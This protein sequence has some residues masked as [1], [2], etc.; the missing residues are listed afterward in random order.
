MLDSCPVSKPSYFMNPFFSFPHLL[1]AFLLY[2][3]ALEHVACGISACLGRYFFN[4]LKGKML[5]YYEKTPAKISCK[6][7]LLLQASFKIKLFTL[8]W[9]FSLYRKSL[10]EEGI[11]KRRISKLQRS[12]HQKAKRKMGIGK[13]IEKVRI[14]YWTDTSKN[15]EISGL[16][17]KWNASSFDF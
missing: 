15:C 16:C 7:H 5:L 8:V 14:K 10:H 1:F 13:Q 11:E 3:I 2:E 4:R 12:E 6:I 9:H 17:V